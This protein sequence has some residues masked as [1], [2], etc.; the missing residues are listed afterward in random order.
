M[1]GE[2]YISVKHIV[3]GLYRDNN[4]SEEVNYYDIIEFI[5]EA[6][7]SIGAYSQYKQ[8]STDLTLCDY[9]AELPCDLYKLLSVS[10]NGS[11]MLPATSTV[12][13]LASTSTNSASINTFTVNNVPTQLNQSTPASSV[14][15]YTYTINDNFITTSLI[16]GTICIAYLG[17]PVDD[18]GFPLIPDNY[19]YVKAVKLYVTYML[20]RMDWRQAKLSDRVYMESKN[21]WQWYTQ[22]ARSAAIMPSID[23]MENFRNQWVRLKPNLTR[24]AGFF[25]D[26]AQKEALRANTDGSRFSRYNR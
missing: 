22:A 8:Q 2:R 6:L 20:D 4:I 16:E 15:N 18:D 21:E 5:G 10:Y 24:H 3:E 1:V 11:P 9:R 7:D 17:I 14:T 13:N 19:Y 12:G 25:K 23:M 26:L